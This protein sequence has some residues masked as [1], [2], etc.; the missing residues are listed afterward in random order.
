MGALMSK[1]AAK[2][3]KAKRIHR[4]E[5]GPMGGI[6]DLS[7]LVTMIRPEDTPFM[8]YVQTMIARSGGDWHG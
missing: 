1:N 2:Q 3:R 7:D 4:V 8:N 6:D 5:F